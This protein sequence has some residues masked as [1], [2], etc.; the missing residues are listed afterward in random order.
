VR[1]VKLSEHTAALFLQGDERATSEVY[2]ALRELLYFIIAS[3]L[4]NKE[5]I[6]DVYQEVFLEAFASRGEAKE[7]KKLQSYLCAL[8]KNRAI[9][10]AKKLSHVEPLELEDEL[11]APEEPFALIAPSLTKK[12]AFVLQARIVFSLRWDEIESLGGIPKTSAKRLYKAAI[13]KLK[14]EKS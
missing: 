7:P 14:G 8:A 11:P 1:A 12:E 3:Y 2:Y 13:R 6:D 5:D 10:A 4:H 9:N